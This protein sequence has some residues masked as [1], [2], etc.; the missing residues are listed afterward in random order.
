MDTVP[1]GGKRSLVLSDLFPFQADT[2]YSLETRDPR[3]TLQA[4]GL[5]VAGADFFAPIPVIRP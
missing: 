1:P 3:L 4:L 2:V 5:S